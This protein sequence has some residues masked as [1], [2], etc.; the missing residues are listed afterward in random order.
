MPE[1]CKLYTLRNVRTIPQFQRLPQ[2]F[3][4]DLR[5]VGQVYPFR[6]NS[7]IV[8]ELIDWNNAPD[9]PIFRLVFPSKEMLAPEHYE[10]IASIIG[11]DAG[12]ERDVDRAEINAA[13][14]D[15]RARLNPHPA[16]QR[17]R[18]M[19][20]LDGKP[21]H[22]I[23]HKYHQTVLFFPNQG[24]TCHAYCSF[25][26]RW[27]Q[28]V[29]VKELRI[30]SREV[31][32]LIEY[33]SRHPEVSDVLLTGGD[34]L[35]MKAKVLA[36][37]IDKLLDAR[38]P[39]LKTIRIGTKTLS[40][41]PYRFITDDDADD[42]LRLFAKITARGKHLAFMAHFNHPKELKTVAVRNAI[43]RIQETGAQI[44]TQSPL[45]SHIND[46]SEAWSEMWKLQTELGCIPYYMFINRDT[47]AQHYFGVPLVRAW[48]IFKHAY[49]NVTGLAR[50]VRGPSMS[51]A[52]GKVQ[53]LG[54][55]K[56]RDERIFVMQFLQ[57]RDPEWVKRPFFA[58]YDEKAT[59]FDELQ[60]YDYEGFFFEKDS[61]QS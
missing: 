12:Q 1:R 25:C 30:A 35:I 48:E 21:L 49:R 45:L 14:N 44:R 19:P 55:G 34:P 60:P 18:N 17:E 23:Q 58:K 42:L 36:P 5:I 41:W 10:K 8:E 29:G 9:D 50:T 38:L 53:I 6:V 56:I 51:T 15:I 32:T 11:K 57:A 31:D 54:V 61:P 59:W 20:H 27:P 2:S 4:S 3:Q 24:Q 47:G 33:L 13:V 37:Y 43:K 46:Q 52:L 22:G 26:F 7:Y 28:F 39:H 16:E 40:H